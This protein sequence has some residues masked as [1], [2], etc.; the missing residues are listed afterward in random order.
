MQKARAIIIPSL[1]EGFGRCM[2][3]AMFNGCLA[4]GRNTGGTLEQLNNGL[5]L[6]GQEIA[7]RFDTN[8]QLTQHLIDVSSQ[9]V[10]Y[11]RPTLERAF[12]VVNQLYSSESNVN[13]VYHFYKQ[14]VV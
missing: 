11:Y 6:T 12:Q 8:Q 2:P 1:N 9:P 5:K 10:D 4:I 7:L 13:N 3:E 14:I